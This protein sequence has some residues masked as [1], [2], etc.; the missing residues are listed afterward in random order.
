MTRSFLQS[1]FRH[2]WALALVAAADLVT[3]QSA[4]GQ[5][6]V[7]GALLVERNVAPGETYQG[8]ILLRNTTNT[9]QTATLTLADYRFTAS[10]ANS[11]DRPGVNARS[12]TPWISLS[13][14]TVSLPPLGSQS[15]SYTV[16]VPTAT[17]GSAAP[18][19]GE[20][21]TPEPFAGSYW[22]VVL[23]E[24][25]D[26]RTAPASS[27]AFT[28]SPK[29]R[30]AVQVVTHVGQGGECRLAFDNPRVQTGKVL[31]DV[32][33]LGTRACRPSLKLEVY[34]ASGAIKHTATVRGPYLYPD[35]ST[36]QPF[37]L[38]PLTPGVYSFQVLADV[39]ADKLQGARFQVQVR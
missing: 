25:E 5:I 37:E 15:V 10:G 32:S 9:E 4:S 13:Q 30:F 18:G 7:T 2:A 16:S 23:V 19:A 6:T 39:G 28:V 14:Q 29:V 1:S 26:R 12:N 33:A 17:P 34:D 38:V 36:R 21:G 3:V 20:T 27:P 22:S 8:E 35:T 24:G 31:I 11:F